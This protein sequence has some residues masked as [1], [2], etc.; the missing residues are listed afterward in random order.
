MAA[1]RKAGRPPLFVLLTYVT[2]PSDRTCTSLSCAAKPATSTGSE[3]TTAAQNWA[4]KSP[5]LVTNEVRNTGAVSA[6]VAVACFS[7][8]TGGAVLSYWQTLSRLLDG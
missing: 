5:W 4:R 6:T 7:T 1:P 3:T 2:E 8:P